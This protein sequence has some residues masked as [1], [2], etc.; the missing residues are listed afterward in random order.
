MP[1]NLIPDQLS[2]SLVSKEKE[3]AK[4]ATSPGGQKKLSEILM[5]RIQVTL[6]FSNSVF[7][8]LNGTKTILSQPVYCWSALE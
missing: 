3:K 1:S 5:L 6:H 2:L 8:R 7:Q 4:I